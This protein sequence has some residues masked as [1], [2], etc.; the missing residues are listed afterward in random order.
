MK[1]ELVPAWLAPALSACIIKIEFNFQIDQDFSSRSALAFLVQPRA[2]TTSSG[3]SFG[4]GFA[5][6]AP[7]DTESS[8]FSF[9]LGTTNLER[10]D[11]FTTRHPD[12][13]VCGA[14]SP[15]DSERRARRT[16]LRQTA[17]KDDDRSEGLDEQGVGAQPLVPRPL[18]PG[19]LPAR[20]RCLRR[21]GS[22]FRTA[23]SLEQ[24]LA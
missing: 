10:Q 22:L 9:L 21:R 23:R 20:L 2:R 11:A 3:P 12:F 24:L 5:E 19:L 6:G 13:G 14:P 8:D 7:I 15:S 4:A 16:A 17:P 18:L 1:Q